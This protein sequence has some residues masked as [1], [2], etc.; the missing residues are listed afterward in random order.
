MPTKDKAKQ[1]KWA[2]AHYERNKVSMKARAKAF[3]ASHGKILCGIIDAI[4]SSPYMDCG[5]KYPPYIM[6]FDHVRGTKKFSIS[7]A[8]R[9]CLSIE[10]LLEEVEKCDVVCSNC[11]RERTFKLQGRV[12]RHQDP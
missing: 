10:R 1:A 5:V 4:K 6:D 2:R 12:T 11:H 3:T 8:P 7:L 9:R